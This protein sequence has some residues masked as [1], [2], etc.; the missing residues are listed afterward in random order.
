MRLPRIRSG[1]PF[2]SAL[3]FYKILFS[4]KLNIT[5][6]NPFQS[7]KATVDKSRNCKF[8]RVHDIKKK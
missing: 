6:V 8:G 4:L 5:L 7:R 1:I 2:L 3:I